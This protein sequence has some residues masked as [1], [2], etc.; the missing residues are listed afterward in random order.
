MVKNPPFAKP[1]WT[2]F[3]TKVWIQGLNFDSFISRC[4]FCDCR[5]SIAPTAGHCSIPEKQC[6]VTSVICTAVRAPTELVQ[7]LW[8]PQVLNQD[9]SHKCTCFS[10]VRAG[11]LTLVYTCGE[12]DPCPQRRASHS[13]WTVGVPRTVGE[14]VPHCS[15]STHRAGHFLLSEAAES[16]Y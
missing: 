3:S 2:A 7:P 4:F 14:C 16:S 8:V 9:L 6:E 5:S 1:A 15:R 13:P 12:F 11:A 10:H